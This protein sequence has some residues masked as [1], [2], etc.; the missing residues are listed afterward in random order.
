MANYQILKADIDEKI[1]E[2]AQQKITGENL[3]S[4]L[5]AMVATLGAEYQFAG[6]A[7]IDTN[8]EASD[9][10]VF[11]IANG[12]G[13]Y[14]YFGGIEVTEDD[15]VILYYDTSWHKVATGI[16]SHK[17]VTE[18]E[19][20]TTKA[21]ND[22]I[23]GEIVQN[24]QLAVLEG[25]GIECVTETRSGFIN[26][27]GNL[28]E[29]SSFQTAIINVANNKAYKIYSPHAGS[30]SL[31]NRLHL[32]AEENGSSPMYG[33]FLAGYEITLYAV[34]PPQVKSISV[35]T[36]INSTLSVLEYDIANVSLYQ[37][38]EKEFAERKIGGGNTDFLMLD[39]Q[40]NI[41]DKNK[42]VPDVYIK[43]ST[44][45]ETAAAGFF[46][47]GYIPV[48]A[49]KTYYM[50]STLAKYWAFYDANKIYLTGEN[51]QTGFMTKITAPAGAS[52]FRFTML[53]STYL[54][55]AWMSAQPNKVEKMVYKPSD[56]L[57]IPIELTSDEL[58]DVE[59]TDYGNIIDR[60]KLM[61][62]YYISASENTLGNPAKFDGFACTDFCEL[63]EG[64]IY[65]MFKVA[66]YYAGFY[67][68]S[69]KCIKVYTTADRLPNPFTP[70]AGAKF[71][72]FTIKEEISSLGRTAYDVCW[73]AA[74]GNQTPNDFKTYAFPHNV[75]TA[76]ETGVNP[77]EYNG[78]EISVFRSLLCIGDSLTFG[79]ENYVGD[80]P[81]ESDVMERYGYPAHL[82]KMSGVSC[83]NKGH[84]GMTTQ[85]WYDNHSGD[86][87]LAGHDGAIIMLGVNDWLNWSAGAPEAESFKTS[88]GRVVDLV[89]EKNSSSTGTNK[90]KVYVA[91]I[92]P[93]ISY[94]E[95]SAGDSVNLL[96]NAIREF[97]SARADVILLDLARYG[98]TMKKMAYNRGHLSAIGYW[99]LAA[100]LHGL[101]SKHIADNLDL[102][103]DLAFIGS[104]AVQYKYS[105]TQW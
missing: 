42:V 21:I 83:L 40:Y 19:Q 79:A 85:G 104:E 72:R 30:E 96:N 87:D 62:G 46:S 93:G 70:P 23:I 32:F 102:Y 4:V 34:F 92:T 8:P 13:K 77:C 64:K 94:M 16:A 55:N 76:R 65:H 27:N 84:S 52:F 35:T 10:K 44:G 45:K 82:S 58:K 47:S 31:I 9:A 54:T 11:Y 7:T 75:Q 61:E 97:C 69:K 80:I 41:F 101:I 105:E 103:V 91:T 38:L 74:N 53:N 3:N 36:S 68:S 2:N 6:V 60:S 39:D 51:D 95:N 49:G 14:S 89:I 63:E 99:R 59:V 15:V 5:N 98:S 48:E 86:S 81:L 22:T 1:Y 12:K 28:I 33:S 100:D 24:G 37:D 50:A 88:L 67:D 57:V 71:A 20:E 25:N 43:G 90:I 56:N 66:N 18:L 26:K 78:R 17:K 29:N 73:C